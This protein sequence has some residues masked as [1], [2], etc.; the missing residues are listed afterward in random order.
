MRRLTRPG[1][2]RV[3]L[4]LSSLAVTAWLAACGGRPDAPAAGRTAEAPYGTVAV[5]A[6][7]MP[8]ER[9]V[10]GRVESLAQGTLTAQTAG[11]VMAL[12]VDIDDRVAAG[13]VLVRLKGTEQRAG[14]AQ[15]EAGLAEATAREAEAQARYRR[16]A[17]MQV[18]KVVPKAALDEAT[19][20]RDAAVARLAAARAAVSAASEAVAYTEV[21][22]PYAGVVT[23][24]LVE[25]GES[26]GPGAPLIGLT[27]P[28][29]LRVV[30]DLPQQWAAAVRSSGKAAIHH[31][32]RR[33]DGAGI[34]VAP[35][36][37]PDSGTVRARVELNDASAS[38]LFPGLIVR[39]GFAVG[40]AERL[41]VPASAVVA[42][43]EVTGVY[44][45]DARGRG[46]T[47]FRQVRLGHAAAGQ[48]EVLAGLVAGERVATDPLAARRHLAASARVEDD[49]E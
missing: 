36:A 24:R 46:R 41:R 42:R 10:D 48:V 3:G 9:F 4:G 5:S 14:L 26:V 32:G 1:I 6:E 44:V 8:V 28:G 7:K 33:I 17:D 49:A 19:A 43:S 25:V 13:A 35:E 21:R 2:R 12:P 37:S 34:T 29:K 31:D 22:A 38:D 39:V 20:G 45:F 27:S 23:R 11:R 16:I 30:V 15:A 18:R 47:A 40:E